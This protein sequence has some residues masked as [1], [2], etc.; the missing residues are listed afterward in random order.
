[1]T[2]VDPLRYSRHLALPQVG[3]SGQQRLEQSSVLV[4]GL[5]GLGSV[6]SLYLANAGVGHLIINDFDKVDVTN[7][8]RQ[9]LF[10]ETDVGEFKTHATAERLRAA[11][12]APHVNVLNRRLDADELRD[13][14]GACDA[15][16]DCTDNFPTRL[17]LNAACVAVRKPLVTGAAIRFEG[18]VA[19]FLNNDS[20]SPCYR[21]LYSDEDENFANCAGQGILAPVAGAIG[22][23]L[24]TEALKLLLGLDSGLRNRLWIYDAL[25][26]ATR[27][28]AIR[29]DP[30]CPVCGRP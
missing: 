7:L 27:M 12:P 4:V 2:T 29:K 30:A 15:V 8:P 17:A 19:V 23:L 28:V 22:A 6:A 16:L 20:D 13:A 14:V 3:E 21:C 26:G 25:T 9:I 18:Q 1:M 11:N 5:G 24:A 10:S